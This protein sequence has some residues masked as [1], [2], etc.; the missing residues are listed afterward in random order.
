M[1]LQLIHLF[2]FT[3][4]KSRRSIWPINN[5]KLATSYVEFTITKIVNVSIHNVGFSH[6][7]M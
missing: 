6:K 2:Q 7:T 1:E 3:T 4:K 5:L